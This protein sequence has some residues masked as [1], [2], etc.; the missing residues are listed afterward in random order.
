[1]IFSKLPVILETM[2]AVTIATITAKVVSN[3]FD[4]LTTGEK[5]NSK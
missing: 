3:V 2:L 1:M 5:I 4:A